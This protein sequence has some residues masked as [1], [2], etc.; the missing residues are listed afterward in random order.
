L[1]LPFALLSDA[2][3]KFARALDLPTFEVAGMELIRR[4][5]LLTKAG[6]IEAVHYP[7]FP[8]DADAGRALEWLRAR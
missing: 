1:H 6:R 4:L 2:D 8:P 7:V 3:L 5:T